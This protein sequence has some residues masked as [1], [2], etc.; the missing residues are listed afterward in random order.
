M[1]KYFIWIIP[2]LVIIIIII[3]GGTILF[4]NVE[5]EYHFT[6]EFIDNE[7]NINVDVFLMRNKNGNLLTYSTNI[8]YSEEDIVAAQLYYLKD[9]EKEIILGNHLNSYN[10]SKRGANQKEYG[11]EYIDNLL[12]NENNLYF[13][14]C[15]DTACDTIFETIKLNSSGL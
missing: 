4:N 8:Y 13:D 14:L 1:K 2:V 9:G 12:N 10:Y 7:N 11:Y 6:G 5:G 15:S 3:L